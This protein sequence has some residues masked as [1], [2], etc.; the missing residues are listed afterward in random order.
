M[1]FNIILGIYCFYCKAYKD[2]YQDVYLSDGSENEGRVCCLKCDNILGY[3]SDIQW[4]EF[5]RN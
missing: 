1:L 4:K 5:W 3:T 2:P